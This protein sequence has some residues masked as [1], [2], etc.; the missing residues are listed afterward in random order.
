MGFLFLGLASCPAF[1]ILNAL[2]QILPP[3][4]VRGRVLALFSG[5]QAGVQL[6]ATLLGLTLVFWGGLTLLLLLAGGFMAGGALLG[7]SKPGRQPD[8]EALLPPMAD[9]CLSL[10]TKKNPH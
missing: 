7:V 1:V 5:L 9:A 3:D 6:V 10:T 8:T 2:S 4:E